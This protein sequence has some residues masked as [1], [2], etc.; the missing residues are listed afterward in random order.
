MND[1][2]F[3]KIEL[4]CLLLVTNAGSFSVGMMLPIMNFEF[5]R[6]LGSLE[7]YHWVTIV[8]GLTLFSLGVFSLAKRVNQA[9]ESA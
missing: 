6:F 2:M 3:L 1:R 8:I 7:A 4:V 9:I 5:G